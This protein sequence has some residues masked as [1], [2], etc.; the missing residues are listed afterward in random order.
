LEPVK[1]LTKDELIAKINLATT[2]IEL[3]A[4]QKDIQS[5]LNNLSK[6]NKADY[7][8]VVLAGSKKRGS[9]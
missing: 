9:L 1:F 7:D 6:V 3:T 4:I 2:G 8:A 5:S